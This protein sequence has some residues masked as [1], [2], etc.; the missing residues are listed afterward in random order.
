[1]IQLPSALVPR[2]ALGA[3]LAMGVVG[4]LAC[5]DAVLPLTT[6]WE[7]TL[8]PLSPSDR[9]SASVGVL[10]QAG[11]ARISIQMSGGAEGR[12]YAW[13]VRE[14][15]CEAP[16][17]TVGG[18]AQYPRLEP[19]A[20]GITTGETVLSRELNP[21]GAYA[22]WIFRVTGTDEVAAACGGLVRG[23]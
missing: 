9:V 20:N 8:S 16:G 23:R 21:E 18:E 12:T 1:M 14:G 10:S 22:G 7:G 13:R 2:R 3:L 5:S 11:R 6:T 15:S 19:N 17:A 4:G